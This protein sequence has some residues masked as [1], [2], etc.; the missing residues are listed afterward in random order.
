M[1]DEKCDQVSTVFP[2]WQDYLPT[3][4]QAP[5]QFLRQWMK[6]TPK[7]KEETNESCECQED[8]LAGNLV[9][10]QKHGH[11]LRRKEFQKKTK[12]MGLIA[13]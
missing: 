11:E 8:R 9:L 7:S 3:G 1:V 12:Q 10:G 5:Q 6:P 13:F 2:K 4:A